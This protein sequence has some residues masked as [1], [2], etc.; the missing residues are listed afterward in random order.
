MAVHEGV[1]LSAVVSQLLA[2]DKDVAARDDLAGRRVLLRV[3]FNVPLDES[4]GSVADD[5]RVR[6]ALPTIRLLLERRAKV[7]LASHFGRPD[8]R[9]QTRD[10]MVA[11]YSLRPVAAVLQRELGPEV[12]RGMAP[13]CIGPAAEAELAKLQDGQAGMPYRTARRADAG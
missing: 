7:V 6:A 5:T 11:M 9:K 13:D 2:P 12:F 10:Q 8:P 4:N 1:T 3:D